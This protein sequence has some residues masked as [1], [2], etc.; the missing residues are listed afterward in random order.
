[1]WEDVRALR[2]ELGCVCCSAKFIELIGTYCRYRQR[3]GGVVKAVLS[4]SQV[5]AILAL[6]KRHCDWMH[7]H[8][9][10]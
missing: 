3:E 5:L 6:D 8:R 9:L 4:E 10:S 2:K 7:V 1:M